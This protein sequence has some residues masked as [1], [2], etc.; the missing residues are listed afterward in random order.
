MPGQS[1]RHV[2]HLAAFQAGAGERGD[3][4]LH[5][6]KLIGADGPGANGGLQ[7]PR[8]PPEAA[9]HLPCPLVQPRPP[10]PRRAGSQRQPGQFLAPPTA[11]RL[12]VRNT[13]FRTRLV[14][15]LL[16]SSTKSLATDVDLPD[17]AS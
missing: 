1:R 12:W 11:T 9:E 4:L 2:E 16:V 5:P 8:M 10:V 17:Y 6:A 13:M 7:R 14:R 15:R 3:G